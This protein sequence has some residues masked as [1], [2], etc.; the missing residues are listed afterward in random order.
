MGRVLSGRHLLKKMNFKFF[1]KTYLFLY[2]GLLF[3]MP[4]SVFFVYPVSRV[5]L[6]WYEIQSSFLQAFLSCFFSVI[7]GGYAGLSLA[8]MQE[9]S[10][11]K[12][13][14]FLFLTPQVIPSL[15]I[16]LSYIGL[17]TTFNIYPQGFW[18]VVGVHVLLNL[19][20]VGVLTAPYIQKFILENK[21]LI[22]LHKMSFFFKI[23][24]LTRSYLKT[25]FL[26]VGLFIFFFA[27]SSLSLP[28]LL[29][30]ASAVSL[31]YTVYQKFYYDSEVSQA[32]FL[33]LVQFLFLAVF[34]FFIRNKSFQLGFKAKAKT[35]IFM[36]TKGGVILGLI[37]GLFFAAPL[38]LKGFVTDFSW[39]ESEMFQAAFFLSLELLV[40]FSFIFILVFYLDLYFS[41]KLSTPKWIFVML[42]A[43]LMMWAMLFYKLD[44]NETRGLTSLLYVF[45]FYPILKPLYLV[46]NSETERKTDVFVSD[47]GASY[48]WLFFNAKLPEYLPGLKRAL[49]MGGFWVLGE[50][51]LSSLTLK[52][53]TVALLIK[54]LISNYKLS[55]ATSLTFLLLIFALVWVL[56]I[57][58]VF[59]CIFLKKFG[60]RIQA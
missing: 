21:N 45:L 41:Y 24:V 59:R 50:F 40:L 11:K 14:S 4:L 32:L 12:I 15:F 22:R 16:G 48:S 55:D 54:S 10:L 57:E 43:P 19:G 13:C 39:L 9:G 47:Y 36:K 34:F 58:V 17:W 27:L 56:L 18:H 33:S 35:P 51:A 26:R 37:P 46:M 3:I 25:I 38:V 2:V 20:W 23:K 30:G 6:P 5:R 8:Q 31:E 1:Q 44:P 29:G 7:L 53:S 52:E 28:M 42:P 60:S 49:Q